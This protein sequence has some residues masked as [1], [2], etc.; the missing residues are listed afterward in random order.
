MHQLRLR[1]VERERESAEKE[2][3]YEQRLNAFEDEY[4]RVQRRNSVIAPAATSINDNNNNQR[5]VQHDK[6]IRESVI[7][8]RLSDLLSNELEHVSK[9]IELKKIV[10]T[11]CGVSSDKKSL[12]RLKN[13]SP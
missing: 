12:K 3:D 8:D 11:E 13:M 7:E 4:S 1:L 2:R 5:Q 9:L 10:L 6:L